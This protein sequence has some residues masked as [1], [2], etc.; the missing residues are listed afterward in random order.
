MKGQA[1]MMEKVIVM[2]FVV[3]IIVA[4]I[5]FLSGWFMLNIRTEGQRTTNERALFIMKNVATNPLFVKDDSMFDDTKLT[6]ASDMPCEAF[7][8]LYGENWYIEVE[9]KF[10]GTEWKICSQNRRNTSYII[11]VNIFEK[12]TGLV[13]VGNLKVGVFI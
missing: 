4:L 3:I 9:N 13:Y 6:A 1:A 2:F 10:D 11:P 8:K 12:H 7:E 5:I